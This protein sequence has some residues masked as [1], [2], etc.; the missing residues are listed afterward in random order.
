VQ[1]VAYD[2]NFISIDLRVEAALFA[3]RRC[4]CFRRRR[5]LCCCCCCRTASASAAAPNRRP[6]AN[7]ARYASGSLR[8]IRDN[9]VASSFRL[10]AA[11]LAC[12][13]ML[14]PSL[15]GSC[16]QPLSGTT[17][18]SRPDGRPFGWHARSQL[19]LAFP[20]G[21]YN[22]NCVYIL[23]FQLSLSLADCRRPPWP[24]RWRV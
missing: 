17:I 20:A 23:I 13:A 2:S 18:R 14:S 8:L 21:N 12:H 11:G 5:R 10:A 1:S 4:C 9:R 7:G 16:L 6:I 15:D 3:R 22:N 19:Q 24:P